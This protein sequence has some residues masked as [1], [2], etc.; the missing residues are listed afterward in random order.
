MADPEDDDEEQATEDEALDAGA[1]PHWTPEA[2]EQR[3]ARIYEEYATRFQR[4]FTWMR[5]DLFRPGLETELQEDAGR[6]DWAVAKQRPLES[7]AGCQ[8]GGPTKPHHRVLPRPENHRVLP[9]RRHR[10]VSGA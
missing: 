3:A 9:V 5:H 8:A 10:A 1:A 4:R 7:G 2:L 6:A